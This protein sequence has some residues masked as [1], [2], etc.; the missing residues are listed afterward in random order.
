MGSVEI[1]KVGYSDYW[2]IWLK[3]IGDRIQLKRVT[4]LDYDYM[5]EYIDNNVDLL[6]EWQEDAYNWRTELGYDERR[7]DYEYRYDDWF[8]YDG[9]LDT[10]YDENDSYYTYDY[11]YPTERE[12]DELIDLVVDVFDDEYNAWNFEMAEINLDS[13]RETVW[14]FYDDCVKYKE[15]QEEKKKP[16]WSAFNYYK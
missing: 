8:N 13:F 1:I 14:R 16:H 10:Y 3:R 5:Q 9:D 4:P 6:S 12:K 7:Q 2:D 15:E 11:F